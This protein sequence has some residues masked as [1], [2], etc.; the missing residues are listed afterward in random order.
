MNTCKTCRFSR[1]FNPPQMPGV[2]RTGLPGAPDLL[3]RI[4]GTYQER[5]LAEQQMINEGGDFFHEPWFFP[6]C[7]KW[8]EIQGQGKAAPRDHVTGQILKSYQLCGRMN[9]DGKCVYHEPK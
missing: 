8:T 1:G 7:E 6:W 9:A 5:Q 3:R 4:N 2:V